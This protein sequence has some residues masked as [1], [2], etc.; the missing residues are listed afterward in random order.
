MGLYSKAKGR[1]AANQ[2]VMR[3]MAAKWLIIV[4]RGLYPVIGKHPEFGEFTLIILPAVFYVY[5]M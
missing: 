1:G 5:R 2:F 3:P 4:K